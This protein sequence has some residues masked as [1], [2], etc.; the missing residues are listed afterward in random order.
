[1]G[2]D[3]QVRKH[4]GSRVNAGRKKSTLDAEQIAREFVFPALC[5]AFKADPGR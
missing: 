1:M 2:E 4:G 5:Q 3:N